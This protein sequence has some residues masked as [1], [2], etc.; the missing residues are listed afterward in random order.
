MR[1]TW[2]QAAFYYNKHFESIKNIALELN[3]KAA[4][5]IRESQS[6][7]QDCSLVKTDLNA[8]QSNYSGLVD[9]IQKLEN[10]PVPLV[11]SLRIVKDGSLKVF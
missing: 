5:A 1:G 10:P 8:I 6:K 11:K 7:F 2:L 4:A 9:A 3:P